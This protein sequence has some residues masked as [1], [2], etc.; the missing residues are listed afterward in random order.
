MTIGPDTYIH[1]LLR[2]CGA[3]NVFSDARERYPVINLREALARRPEAVLLPDEPYRFGEKHA[4]EVIAA[5]PGLRIHLVD[6]KQ[7]CWYGPRIAEAI[8]HFRGLLREEPDVTGQIVGLTGK[9]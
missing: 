9:D 7:L 6:G 1:D 3:E 5:A 2:V 4:S 8:R